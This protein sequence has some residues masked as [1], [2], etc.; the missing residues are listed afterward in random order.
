MAAT[1]VNSR[2]RFRDVLID[3]CGTLFF[4]LIACSDLVVSGAPVLSPFICPIL[5]IVAVVGAFRGPERHVLL[6]HPYPLFARKFYIFEIGEWD[7]ID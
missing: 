5:F 3:L 4:S 2:S 1:S 7:F 6:W